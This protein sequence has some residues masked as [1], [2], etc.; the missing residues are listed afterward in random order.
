M[1]TLFKIL[2]KSEEIVLVIMFALMVL[3][4][5]MNIVMR[6][7]FKDS[8]IWSEEI[9]KLA[10]IWISWIGISIGEK[11]GEHIKISILVDKM[12]DKAQ[13]VFNIL[14]EFMVIAIC[15]VTVY[16]SYVLILLQQSTRYASI[17]ISVKWGYMSVLLGCVLMILRCLGSCALSVKGLKENIPLQELMDLRAEKELDPALDGAATASQL[18]VAEEKQGGERK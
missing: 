3:I 4:T 1:K 13:H 2:N 10:F 7:V 17:P 11:R 12:K 9:G 16:Y 18:T 14:S 15:G 6:F 5:F 8:L